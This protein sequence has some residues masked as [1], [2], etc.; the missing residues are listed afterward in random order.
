MHFGNFYRATWRHFGLGAALLSAVTNLVTPSLAAETQKHPTAPPIQHVIVIIGENR[1]FD[2]VFATYQ[3]PA[4]QKVDNLLSKGIINA[5]GTPGPHFK[6]GTQFRASD[7]SR[8]EMSP[9]HTG[10]WKNLPPTNT[11]GT[12]TAPSDAHPAPFQTIVA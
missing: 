8:F 12:P 4:G 3:P 2:H 5:D 7:S 11:Q 6:R 10:P 9:F 1:T